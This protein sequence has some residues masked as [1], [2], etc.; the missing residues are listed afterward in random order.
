VGERAV[1][2]FHHFSGL[3]RGIEIGTLKSKKKREWKGNKENK[4][5]GKNAN[6][7]H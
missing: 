1:S 3:G 5:K 6:K 2:T 7:S 4:A